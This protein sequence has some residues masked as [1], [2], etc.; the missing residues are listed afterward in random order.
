MWPGDEVWADDYTPLGTVDTNGQ[1]V[2]SNPQA[3]LN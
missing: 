2:Q 1:F 3:L